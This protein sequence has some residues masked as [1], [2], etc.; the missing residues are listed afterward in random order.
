MKTTT[1][2]VMSYILVLAFDAPESYLARH[3]TAHASAAMLTPGVYVCVC[4]CMWVYSVVNSL[5]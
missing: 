1:Y 3:A 4:V 5:K 2:S